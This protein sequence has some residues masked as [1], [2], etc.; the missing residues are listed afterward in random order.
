MAGWKFG[1]LE[2]VRRVAR[3]PDA[4]HDA[5]RAPVQWNCERDDLLKPQVLEGEPQAGCRGL[6]GVT[7]TPVLFRKPPTDLDARREVRLETRYRE[8]DKANEWL[9]P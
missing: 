8:A 5:H 1:M 9:T 6:T 2:V 4:F 3:H 7:V